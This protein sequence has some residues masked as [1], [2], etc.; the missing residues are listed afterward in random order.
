MNVASA[1]CLLAYSGNAVREGG[2]CRGRT[3]D[4][5]RVGDYI[6]GID[7]V[8]DEF[9]GPLGVVV[10]VVRGD[11]FG[12]RSGANPVDVVGEGHAVLTARRRG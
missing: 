2:L 7:R 5:V 10:I 9:P 12:R 1:M 8:K 3:G 11:Q 4:R 6:P